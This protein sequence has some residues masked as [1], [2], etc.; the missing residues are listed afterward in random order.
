MLKVFLQGIHE[1]KYLS[2]DF[3]AK[4]DGLL[5]NRKCVPFDFGPS[6]RGNDKT[7]KYHFLDLNSPQGSHTLSILPEQVTKIELM[8]ETFEPS[9]YISWS[10]NWIIDRNWGEH[11]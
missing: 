11:S 10:P 6:S 3:V 4:R 8:N 1:K 7:D 9:K 5:R 2:V